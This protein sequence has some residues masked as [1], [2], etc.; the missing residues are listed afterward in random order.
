MY[1]QVVAVGVTRGTVDNPTSGNG[2]VCGPLAKDQT[3]TQEEDL[4]LG[5]KCDRRHY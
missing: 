2:C 1:E 5:G 4:T 3:H